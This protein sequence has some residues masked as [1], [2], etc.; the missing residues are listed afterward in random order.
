MNILLTFDNGYTPHAAV[1]MESIIANCN[2]PKSLTFYVLFNDISIENQDILKKHFSNRIKELLFIKVEDTEFRGCE[3]CKSLA[4]IKNS[5]NV[6]LRLFLDKIPNNDWILYLDC[7]II[8]QDDVNKLKDFFNEE[9][10]IGAVTE[11]NASYKLKNLSQLSKYEYPSFV[12]PF[13]YE[14]YWYRAL[15]NLEM[16]LDGKYFCAGVMLV[17]LRLWKEKKFG[18]KILDYILAKPKECFA[19]D[20]DALNHQVNGDY[21]ELPPRW[22]NNVTSDAVFSNY[23]EY[24]LKEAIDNPAIIHVAG[25]IKPWMYMCDRKNKGLYIKY[26]KMTPWPQIVYPDKT[27]L[28]II[29]VKFISH[30][31]KFIVKLLSHRIKHTILFYSRYK[32]ESNISSARII[33]S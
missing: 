15:T 13:Q 4:H 31:Y 21:I 27:L 24:D 9:K 23:S 8:V 17:N 7:D 25:P 3:N 28:N 5:K 20:Q 12:D 26:R 14:A 16:N 6:L 30:I 11:Y 18:N 32:K 1:V 29:K 22:G 19:L 2:N 10:V 33:N